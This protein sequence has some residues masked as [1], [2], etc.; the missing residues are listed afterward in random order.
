[1]NLDISLD[2]PFSTSP[3]LAVAFALTLGIAGHHALAS[4]IF[5]IPVSKFV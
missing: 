4:P 3:L 1:V 5:H 2:E